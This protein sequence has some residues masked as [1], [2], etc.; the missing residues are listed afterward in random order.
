MSELVYLIERAALGLYLLCG[1]SFLFSL[2][3]WMMAQGELRRAEFELERELSMRKQAS[4]M[5]WT[6]GTVEVA[7]AVFAIANVV[8]PTLRADALDARGIAATQPDTSEFRTATPGGKGED[9]DEMFATVTAQAAAGEGGPNLLL[10]PVPTATA[11][12][13]IVPEVQAVATEGCDTDQAKLH[14]PANGQQVFDSITIEGQAWTENFS[15][16]KF[17]IAG[18][19]TAGGQFAPIGNIGTTAV[20][21]QGILG[22]VSLAGLQEGVYKFRLVVFDN[23]TSMKAFCSV[24]IL[25]TSRPPTVTPPGGGAAPTG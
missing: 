24:N 2:R 5:T 10:T 3:R 7:L 6:I 18:D 21:E 11:V 16:Y 9:V 12:G 22:Q 20:R 14:I 1:V 15:S 23:T 8:A 4:A 19:S 17:E 25:L 13:T